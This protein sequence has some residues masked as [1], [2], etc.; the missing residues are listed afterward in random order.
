[1]LVTG[2]E[3]PWGVA[4]LPDGAALV[5][6]RKSARLLR[7]APDGTVTPVGTVAGVV[8]QGEGGLPDLVRSCRAP[9]PAPVGVPRCVCEL[10]RGTICAVSEGAA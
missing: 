4:F 7:V 5:T 9:R 3:V 2:L 1:M 6:E 8:A 10:R